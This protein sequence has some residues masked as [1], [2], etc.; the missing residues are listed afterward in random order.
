MTNVLDKISNTILEGP[1]EPSEGCDGEYWGYEKGEIP[2]LRLRKEREC[3]A[4]IY[5]KPVNWRI[6]TGSA[7]V[8]GIVIYHD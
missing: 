5:G 6:A 2:S 4:C 7:S 1:L 3:P 8:P